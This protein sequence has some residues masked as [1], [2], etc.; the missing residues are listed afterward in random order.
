ML[1]P[2]E[3][4]PP[5]ELRDPA[6]PQQ[7][8]VETIPAPL[9]PSHEIIEPESDQETQRDD[10]IELHLDRSPRGIQGPKAHDDRGVERKDAERGADMR[11]P[12]VDEQMME[13][14]LVGMERRNMPPHTRRHDAQ[15]IEHG[16]RQHGERERDEPESP[17]GE[18]RTPTTGRPEYG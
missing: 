4:A 11:K 12:E 14:R 9:V 13:V 10:G 2:K 17:G 5:L 15:G 8:A 7:E 3:D 1:E 6:Q 16:H 18:N